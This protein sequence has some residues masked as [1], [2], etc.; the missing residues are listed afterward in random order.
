LIA[1]V[2]SVDPGHVG[3]PATL[4]AVA[5]HANRRLQQADADLEAGRHAR[6][7]AGYR[8]VATIDPANLA[9]ARGVVRVAN[10]HAARS[11]R[12]AED[13]RFVQARAE[14]LEAERIAPN[15]AAVIA[16]RDHLA[17]ARQSQAR[18]QNALPP[19]ERAQRVRTLIDAAAAARARGDLLDPPG[20]SA[21]DKV[22]AAQAIA[23]R[24]PAVLA[25]AARLLPAARDCFEQ[26]LRGNR[27]TRAHA[28]LDA[29][30][31]LGN[32]DPA[33]HDAR[34]RLALRWIA[35]GDERLGAGELAAAQR[36]LAAATA[37]DPT[38]PALQP[39]SQ[40]VR[41]AGALAD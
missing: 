22:K 37:L 8:A 41:R 5:A 36:A 12:F 29:W 24:D 34:R 14:L 30:M 3:L 33:L 20:E 4:A 28:C 7:L 38:L 18:L 27:L 32:R 15:A 1:R 6:A 23:P 13:F 19:A 21:Y 39:F 25:M 40:R 10:A 31:L 35:V 16:A 9:A 2:Q 26:H 11:E 17:R